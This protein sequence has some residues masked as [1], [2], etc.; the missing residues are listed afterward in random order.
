VKLVA[1]DESA[2]VPFMVV[3]LVI[4]ALLSARGIR[5]AHERT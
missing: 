4:L 5:S 2:A 1:Y 3:D